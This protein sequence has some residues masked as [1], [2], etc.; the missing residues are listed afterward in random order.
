MSEAI[1][2]LI[3][4]GA[5]KAADRDEANIQEWIRTA[6]SKLADARIPQLSAG[7][8]FLLAYEGIHA[9]ATAFLNHHEAR[10]GDG[11]GHR[12]NALQLAAQELGF[13]TVAA[14]TQ[15]H[16]A[17]NR[18]TYFDP[19]PPVSEKLASLTVDILAKAVTAM[20]VLVPVPPQ[21]Q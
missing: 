3:R 4:T 5:L 15:I 7:S 6:E 19:I 9:I 14:V 13:T 17:R 2:N 21:A 10:T 11:E 8:R 20:R 16:R 18:T 1:R 12:N